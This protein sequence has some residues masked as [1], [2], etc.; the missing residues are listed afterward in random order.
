MA[1]A[2]ARRRADAMNTASLSR[3]APAT[4]VEKDSR[5]W[6][7]FS[8]TMSSRPGSKIGISPALSLAMRSPILVDADDR[9]A[10][11]GEAGAG[12][13]PDI[14]AADHRYTHADP[15]LENWPQAEC[16]I[17]AGRPATAAQLHKGL[18]EAD[19]P[20]AGYAVAAFAAPV[21]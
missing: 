18:R 16:A 4:S 7:T 11:I 6:P 14:A 2:A 5:R 13:Q 17:G 8:A 3:T 10:E 12:N 21:Y 1:V 15:F 20:T 19:Q 9:V